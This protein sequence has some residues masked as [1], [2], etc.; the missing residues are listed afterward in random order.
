MSKCTSFSIST[1]LRRCWSMT[2][3]L[4]A[5]CPHGARSS[6]LDSFWL[7]TANSSP[8]R[9]GS[10]PSR[11][12]SSMLDSFRL[13][14]AQVYRSTSLICST[15]QGCDISLL[16]V[17]WLLQNASHETVKILPFTMH[18][19]GT[20]P[21]I[22]FSN[23]CFKRGVTHIQSYIKPVMRWQLSTQLDSMGLWHK[24]T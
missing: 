16:L 21:A 12:H 2:T 3:V 20:S 14:T 23:N 4:G 5:P 22:T 8:P 19:K 1:L 13:S 7:L 17:A 15:S 9:W 10:W 6:V 11:V 18:D 24:V